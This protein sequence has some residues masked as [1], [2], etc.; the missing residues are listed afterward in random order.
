MGIIEGVKDF[1]KQSKRV[2]MVTHKPKR[3]EFKHI[4]LSTAIGMALVGVI[5]FIISMVA[6][7]L[8][9]G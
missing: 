4:A 9:G 5:G 7:V 8:R 1:V 3:Y 6:F 2:L